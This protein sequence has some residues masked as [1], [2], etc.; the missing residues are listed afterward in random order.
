MEEAGQICE[1][2]KKIENSHDVE[3]GET[4]CF[5]HGDYQYHNILRQDRGFFLVNFEKCQADGPIRDLYLLLRKLLEK[6]DW[7]CNR[8][9]SPAGSL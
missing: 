8:G 7:D 6:S 5:C 4:F 1:E 9:G 3:A 2:W